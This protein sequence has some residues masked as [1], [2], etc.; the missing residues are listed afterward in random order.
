MTQFSFSAAG[1]KTCQNS[2]WL[3]TKKRQ[4]N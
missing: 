2:R 4:K 1:F 3:W